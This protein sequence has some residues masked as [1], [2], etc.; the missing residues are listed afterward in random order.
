V[1][2]RVAIPG[3]SLVLPGGTAD[4]SGY[5]FQAAMVEAGDGVAE[6]DGSGEDRSRIER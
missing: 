3:L 4:R 5:Q 6:A 1:I 2:S